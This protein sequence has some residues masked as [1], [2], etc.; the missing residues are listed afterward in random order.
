MAHRR[1][2]TTSSDSFEIVSPSSVISYTR[3]TD[4]LSSDDEDQIVWG[5]DS[6]SSLRS[7][8]SDEDFI[9]LHGPLSPQSAPEDTRHINS[10]TVTRYRIDG[11]SVV[12]EESS[13]RAPSPAPSS[14]TDP[15][16]PS[17]PPPRSRRRNRPKPT[18]R[19]PPPIIKT[20]TPKKTKQKDEKKSGSHLLP[21]SPTDSPNGLG[22]R[23]IVDDMSEHGDD[24]AAM[25][26]EEA[27][28]Y[29]NW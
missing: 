8:L 21:I 15:T 26:Y 18:P 1:P 28:R 19:S 13:T 24:P 12:I 7:P 2:S 17:S 16:P 3:V 27:V 22:A 14:D 9:L 20:P 11:P 10:I 29:I 25:L 23:S 6:I 4:D 5:I